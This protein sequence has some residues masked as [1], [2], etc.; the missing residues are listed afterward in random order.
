M[1]DGSESDVL[2]D[3]LAARQLGMRELLAREIA[4]LAERERLVFTLYYYEELET[5]EIARLLGETASA[6]LQLHTS[7]LSRLKIRLADA[8]ALATELESRI[9]A[10]GHLQ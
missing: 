2:F 5:A 6:V 7:V 3:V 4:G 8:E 1:P 9:T 10:H